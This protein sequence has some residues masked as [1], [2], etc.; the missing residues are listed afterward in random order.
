MICNYLAPRKVEEDA[1]VFARERVVY[2]HPSRVRRVFG[3]LLDERCK[4][5]L[6]LVCQRTIDVR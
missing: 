4:H 5:N 1:D 6:R 2:F 3:H